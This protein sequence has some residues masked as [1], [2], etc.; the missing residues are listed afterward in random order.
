MEKVGVGSHGGG[1][2]HKHT[3]TLSSKFP[4]EVVD[5]G[6]AHGSR[7]VLLAFNTAKIRVA[8]CYG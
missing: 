1:K 6:R 2:T 8:G 5:D 4:E 3:H 7:Q